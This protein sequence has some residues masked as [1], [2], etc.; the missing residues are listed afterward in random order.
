[1]KK[2][3]GWDII[4]DV[5]GCFNEMIMLASMMGYQRTENGGLLHPDGRKIAWVGDIV[6]RGPGIVEALEVVKATVESGN[7]VCVQ[8]NHED[9]YL[10]WFMNG[11]FNTYDG[12]DC[13][14]N[15]IKA[16]FYSPKYWFDFIMKLPLA[17]FLECEDGTKIFLS[18]AGCDYKYVEHD[19]DGES[20]INFNAH[21]YHWYVRG[22]LQWNRDYWDWG[23]TW[24][25]K[26]YKVV[27]GHTPEENVWSV[28]PDVTYMVDTGCVYEGKLSAMRFP[29][30]EV[31]EVKSMTEWTGR[32]GRNVFKGEPSEAWF[33]GSD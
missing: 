13:T 26:G 28:V 15:Q 7:G 33:M 32:I 8:G 16:S 4:G 29:E 1:M 18:H 9:M 20:Y 10:N 2:A 5:H 31:F 25:G 14:I 12:T 22:E 6:D 21:Q 23:P 30:E 11:K 27:Y 17:E 19:D 3:K 24:E